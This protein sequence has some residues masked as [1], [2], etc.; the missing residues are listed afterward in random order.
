[1]KA[2]N[3]L[4][5]NKLNAAELEQRQ[6]NALRGGYNCGCGCNYWPDKGGQPQIENYNAN[7]R[8]G[9]SESGGGNRAC[10]NTESNALGSTH[11]S[12][13]SNGGYDELPEALGSLRV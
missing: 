12:P 6:M 13:N 4:K 10:G 9:Y 7:V 11:S 3:C 2:L 5:L 1:M 8:Q